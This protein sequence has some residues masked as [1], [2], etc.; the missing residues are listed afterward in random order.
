MLSLATYRPRVLLLFSLSRVKGLPL[1]KARL[2]FQSGYNRV[3][4]GA[5]V[6]FSNINGTN[7]MHAAGMPDFSPGPQRP[8]LRQRQCELSSLV[9]PQWSAVTRRDYHRRRRRR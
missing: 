1:E 6:S 9:I 2:A 5:G 4:K 7:G 8:L 3:R